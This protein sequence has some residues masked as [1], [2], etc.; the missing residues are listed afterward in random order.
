MGRDALIKYML[1][2]IAAIFAIACD[3]N[4]KTETTV[5]QHADVCRQL[6]LPA[7]PAHITDPE[8]RAVFLVDHYWDNMDF[9]DTLRSHNRDFME[10][11]FSNYIALLPL[12]DM[13]EA[14]QSI[15][16]LLTSAKADTTAYS[17]IQNIAH[18]YLY[19][20]N[21]PML[22][23]DYYALFL[24]TLINDNNIDEG[25][26]QRYIFDQKCI[27]MNRSGSLASDFVYTDRD[28]RKHRLHDTHCADRLML[29]FYDPDCDECKKAIAEMR[30]SQVLNDLI[31]EGHV[32][33]LAICT[34][35][36]KAHWQK[37]M[38]EMP[39]NW[40]VGYDESGINDNDIYILRAMPTIYILDADK[41]VV[42]KDVLMNRA[43]SALSKDFT[44][45]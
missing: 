2:V 7:V 19:E 28:G 14:S 3:S 44:G 6:E 35:G 27:A 40:V 11:S 37:T 31:N 38:S 33:V 5:Q 18:K 15:A 4:D 13:D 39:Y 30:K 26:R 43:I 17:L 36:D 10:Q 8:A 41:H 16:D 45:I 12:V 1:T 9:G 23:E 34:E 21:S 32:T 20:P 24:P 29:I 22:N 42:M 25:S